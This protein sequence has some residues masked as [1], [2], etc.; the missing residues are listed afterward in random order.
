MQVV[1][2]AA[3]P[4]LLLFATVVM[5]ACGGAARDAAETA[6]PSS[7]TSPTTPTNNVDPVSIASVIGAQA[8]TVGVPFRFDA[9]K[10]GTAFTD[11]R[12][13]GLIYATTL[14]GMPQGLSAVGCDI[15]GTPTTPGVHQVT[16]T[17][18]DSTG[19]M[20]TQQFTLVVFAADLVAPTLPATLHAYSDATSP[21]PRHF[22]NANT[23]ALDNTPAANP[24]TDAGATLGRV[25]F[26]D[27]RLSANDRVACASCHLQANGFADTARLSRGFAGG[28]TGRHSMALANARWYQNGRFFWDE[29]AASLEAQVLAPIQ[30]ATEMG[31]TFEQLVAKVGVSSYYAPLFTAAFGTAEVT[32]DRISRALAQFVRSLV[33]GGAKYDL[34]VAAGNPQSGPNFAAVFTAQEQLGQQLFVGRGGCARCHTADV[35]ASDA[36]HNT[37]LDA[38]ITDAGAGNG[39]FKAP[40]LR[41]V[42]ARGRFMH[43]GRFATLEQVVEFYDNGV[44]NNPGL[45]NRLRGGQGGNGPPLRLG[46]SRQEKDALVA[47]LGTL[48]DQAFLTN[49]K[50]ANPFAR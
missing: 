22:T 42:A 36:V 9:S 14:A 44:Q 15:I 43:D 11:P 33:S 8:A 45:D 29:R 25:L 7:P 17:A 21:L 50:F 4:V 49:A 26:Y 19:R 28:L 10:G 18:R 31:L 24:V 48:T 27:R 40:S 16:I 41:N 5:C 13:T 1:S 12:K 38:T 34:A 39:R 23:A 32:S 46:L 20:A 47:F 30:D 37:G 2:R 3:Q 6:G 35:H